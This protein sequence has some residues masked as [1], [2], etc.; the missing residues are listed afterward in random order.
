VFTTLPRTIG[1]GGVSSDVMTIELRDGDNEPATRAEA[2]TVALSS[3]PSAGVT[4]R[5]EV[6]DALGITQIE[7]PS[8]QISASFRVRSTTAGSKTITASADGL[9]EAT[10]TLIVHPFS[11]G[12]GTEVDPYV[13]KDV[14]MLQAM[15]D[16]LDKHFILGNNIDALATSDLDWD[17]GAGFEPVGSSFSTS[18]TGSLDGA[19]FKIT[20]LTIDRERTE[21]V[22][23]FGHTS[24]GANIS[25]VSLVEVNVK[26]HEAVGGLVGFLGGG[27]ITN[28]YSSGL[29]TGS[30]AVGGLVGHNYEGS[31]TN[32]YTSGSVTGYQHI[33]GLSGYMVGTIT[34]SYSNASV[35][36]LEEVGGLIGESA[37]GTITNS[38][39]TGSVSGSEEIEFIGG[40][41]G[42]STNNS[43]VTNSYW[44]IDT[45]GQDES[46]GGTGKTT[47]DMKDVDTFAGWDFDD[48]W[49]IGLDFNDGYPRLRGFEY[50]EQPYVFNVAITGELEVDVELT[51]T[52]TFSGPTGTSE[53]G[54]VFQWFRSNDNLGANKADIDGAT[55]KTYTTTTDDKD[56]FL[57]V[58]VTPVTNTSVQG[59]PVESGYVGPFILNPPQ[60]F[61]LR[62]PIVNG[63][64]IPVTP[65][66][67]WDKSE[68]AISYILEIA[69]S[70][71]DTPFFTSEA[72]TPGEGT[73]VSYTLSQNDKL[74]FG[75]SYKWR[76]RASNGVEEN[77]AAW[78]FF[79]TDDEGVTLV[80][81]GD[82]EVFA[83]LDELAEQIF[84]WSVETNN[85]YLNST[86]Y[87]HDREFELDQNP[88][89]SANSILIYQGAE[90]EG[91]IVD[92]S[93][94]V[95]GYTYHW[96][97]DVRVED[98][99]QNG[100]ILKSGFNSFTISPEKPTLS[101]PEC[102]SQ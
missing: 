63:E 46:A 91:Q 68:N 45:S 5:N 30:D 8:G 42:N 74:K 50:T 18:F 64:E 13:I 35:E 36:G 1:I 57:S 61:E 17:N 21:F 67:T 75:F 12:S 70:V 66:F 102:W 82:A 97:V 55:D 40:L 72:I 96:R 94:F 15:K 22:G 43:T 31:I 4:F 100:T 38:Y 25:N 20:D 6:D 69:L 58:R 60:A 92:R 76:V 44:D 95:H 49:A 37:R 84:N 27:T 28:S 54:T 88:A 19:G 2:T 53:Q 14:Y 29:V 26:G 32:S 47:A 7:I 79:D 39:S 80:S 3:D 99:E 93:L 89:T 90:I 56:K 65:T 23:L 11:Y 85:T 16:Y 34:N 77:V 86:L 78:R 98:Q 51:A 71:S 62:L 101:A 48:T 33:G 81:P 10:Q 9:E 87:M 52:Y 73:Q 83:T 41:I 24:T 59:V